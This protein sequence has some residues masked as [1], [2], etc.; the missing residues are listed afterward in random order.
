MA[1]CDVTVIRA[2]WSA[3]DKDNTVGATTILVKKIP[4]VGGDSNESTKAGK[5]EV[6]VPHDT[7]SISKG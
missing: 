2:V 5:F 6:K 4:P 1:H 7:A 3:V